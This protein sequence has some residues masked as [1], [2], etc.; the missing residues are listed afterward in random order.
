M[1]LHAEKNVPLPQEEVVKAGLSQTVNPSSHSQF[2]SSKKMSN[3]QIKI[4]SSMESHRAP[5]LRT[6]IQN[7]NMIV[8]KDSTT[9]EAMSKFVR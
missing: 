6:L 8:L 1:G 2:S 7:V 3:V 5:M 4:L 9:L